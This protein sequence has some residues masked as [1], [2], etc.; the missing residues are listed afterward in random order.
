MGYTYEE[1]ARKEVLET[2][3]WDRTWWEHTEDT[4]T[5]RVLLIGDSI[6]AGY[7]EVIRNVLDGKIH[8]DG[9]RTSKALD[10]PFLLK[11]IKLF[12]EQMQRCD[13]LHVN[14]GL[15]GWHL[16]TEEYEAHYREFLKGL[17]EI[18]PGVPIV[19]ALTTPVRIKETPEIFHPE[20]T[21]LVNERNAA[22]IRI[23]KDFGFE[24]NDLHSV[25][26]DHPEWSRDGVHQT[27]E[28]YMALAKQIASVV[29]KYIG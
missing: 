12:A 7:G 15:H 6:S 3:E 29:K 16:S 18:F 11:S 22:A 8:A 21:P 13:L 25:I 2:Y 27:E 4:Q 20:R 26:V 19:I 17:M 5:P 24:V 23:A 14:N 28:G 10:N 9:F 1:T